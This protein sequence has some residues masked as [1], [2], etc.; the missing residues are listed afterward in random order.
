MEFIGLL[1]LRNNICLVF[2]YILFG[3]NWQM[4][5]NILV[6]LLNLIN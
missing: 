6:D 1:L 3:I 5:N 4:V 2:C